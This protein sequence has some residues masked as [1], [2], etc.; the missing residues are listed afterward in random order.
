MVSPILSIVIPIYNGERYI[1]RCID[2]LSTIKEIEI[3]AVDDG[4]KDDTLTVLLEYTQILDNIKVLHKENGGVSSARN[5]GID[6]C[7]G[8]YVTFVDIDDTVASND[9][10]IV[11][12]K[13]KKKQCDL[14]LFPVLRGNLND[15]F[16]K[17]SHM[18]RFS[19]CSDSTSELY[20]M[21]I[22][23][24]TNELFS[25][26]FRTDIIR[27][28]KIYLDT[29]MFM[30]E[31]VVFLMDYLMFLKSPKFEYFDYAYYYYYCT[32]SGVTSNIRSGFPRQEQIRYRKIKALISNKQLGNEYEIENDR[33]YLHKLIYFV[34]EM[35]KNG[36]NKKD[37][38]KELKE[39]GIYEDIMQGKF[40]SIGDMF[41]KKLFLSLNVSAMRFFVSCITAY[42][43]LTEKRSKLGEN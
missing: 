35:S 39:T 18:A 36:V 42:H 41:R 30:G 29:N 32:G 31:D 34:S 43:T 4:S 1:K 6:N 16:Y 28:N 14:Y 25:K 21:I 11:L 2:S 7:T 22:Q 17:E 37:I 8:E 23:G 5:L 27:R 3:I 9:L 38:K 13:I 33:F 24:K 20:R 12:D 26:I 40:V 10:E 19:S 15:Y